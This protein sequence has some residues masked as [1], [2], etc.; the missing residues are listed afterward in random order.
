M[1]IYI[2]TGTPGTG[3]TTI[4]KHLLKYGF[5]VIDLNSLVI[6]K[7]LWRAK[8]RGCKVVNI[9]ALQKEVKSEILRMGKQSDKAIVIEGHLACELK[10]PAD[11]A[12]ILR[13]RPDILIKRLKSRKYPN[14]KISENVEAELVDY[15]TIRTKE[16]YNCKIYEID[17]S[18]SLSSTL[19]EVVSII[20]NK[21]IPDKRWDKINWLKYFE[22]P[23][24]SKYL[25]K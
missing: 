6:K 17:S 18:R 15:C 7:R 12:I 4:A 11:M 19:K 8:E 16:N 25:Y 14:Y 10:I 21:K 24:V 20:S 5:Q 1:D 3:K 22:H 9:P 2:L 23:K 13:T